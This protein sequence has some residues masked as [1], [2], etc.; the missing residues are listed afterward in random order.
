MKAS[1]KNY[2]LLIFVS[3]FLNSCAAVNVTTSSV[4]EK[5]I[6]EAIS[7]GIIDAAIN[8]EFI[9]HNVNMFINVEIEVVEGRVLLT[10]S[11]KIPKHRLDAVKLSWKVLG[12]R[13][14][15]NEI[16]VTEKGGIKQYLIDVKIKTQIRYKIIADKKIASIN[17]NFEAVNGNLYIIGIANNKKELKRVVDHANTINGIIKVVSHVI[18]KD[19]PRRKKYQ[20]K[21]Q[22]KN[23]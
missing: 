9:N 17:Y 3:I 13:E 6:K 23:E 22:K 21:L 1:F 18:M 10:G 20:R 11:V 7:D 19:D 14:V 12:V 8:K 16:D 15:I 4:K 2:L 5:G